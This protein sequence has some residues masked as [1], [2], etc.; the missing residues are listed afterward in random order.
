MIIRVSYSDND[1]QAAVREACEKILYTI[2]D[3]FPA[4]LESIERFEEYLAKYSM[5]NLRQRIVFAAV[6]NHIAF[7]GANG[8]FTKH[9][10]TLAT[11]DEMMQY[12]DEKVK[13]ELVEAVGT[14]WEN[15]EVCFIDLWTKEVVV[16]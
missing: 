12:L 6:G 3:E 5:E 16:C 1:L 11:F 14:E 7:K 9:D 15:G 13:V 10:E 4:G 2:A 8:R